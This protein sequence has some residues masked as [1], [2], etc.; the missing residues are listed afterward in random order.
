MAAFLLGQSDPAKAGVGLAQKHAQIA[1]S[2]NPATIC[3][4]TTATHNSITGAFGL[5]GNDTRVGGDGDT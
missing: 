4:Q 1:K 3:F 2:P 5:L